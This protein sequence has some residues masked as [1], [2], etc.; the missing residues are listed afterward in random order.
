MNFILAF[1]IFTLVAMLSGF[2][3]TDSNELGSVSEVL[4]AGAVLDVGDRIVAVNGVETPS[5]D[6]FTE[7]MQQTLGLRNITLTIERNGV[8]EDVVLNPRLF[9]YSVGFNSHPEA[10]TDLRIGPVV[11]GTL[12]AQA[13]IQEN[14]VIVAIDGASVTTWEAVV[15]IMQEEAPTRTFTLLRQGSTLEVTIEPFETRLLNAQGVRAV[16]SMIG[17]SPTS[18]FRFFPSF[19]QGAL[20]TLGAGRMIFDTLSLLANSN[21]VGVGDLAGPIGIFTI[22]SQ[23]RAQGFVV[24]LNWV[25]LLSVNL[26]ILNLMPIPALDGGRLVFIG[27]EAITRRKVNK[28]F[29]NALHLLVFFMLI[30]LFVFVAFNDVLRLFN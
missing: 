10:T 7:Q 23:A 28:R 25:G 16:E 27:Y 24:L 29:E 12:A 19:T 3:V 2:P 18:E 11:S 17:V 9:F 22:T 13:G 20:G 26:G 15:Q 5:W 1:I 21:Q 4:P 6:A 14:D 8:R 30:T